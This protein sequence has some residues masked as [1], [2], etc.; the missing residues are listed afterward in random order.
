MRFVCCDSNIYIRSDIGISAGKETLYYCEVTDADKVNSDG[1]V[2][3]E[4]I[5]I[6]ELTIDDCQNML[7]QTEINNS[8]PSSVLGVSW[9]LGNKLSK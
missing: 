7:K 9:F 6:I 4:I 3:D 2:E 5:D 8:P 1:S